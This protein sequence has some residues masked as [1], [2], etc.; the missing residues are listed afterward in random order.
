MPEIHVAAYMGDVQALQKH[1]KTDS[2]NLRAMNGIT[3]LMSA[4]FKRQQQTYQLLVQHGADPNLADDD[5]QDTLSYVM[6]KDMQSWLAFVIQMGSKPDPVRHRG[7]L[8]WVTRYQ[9]RSLVETILRISP[10]MIADVD[11]RR[12]GVLHTAIRHRRLVPDRD[13]MV[14]YLLQRGADPLALDRQGRSPLQQLLSYNNHKE[15][16][17]LESMLRNAQNA[18]ARVLQDPRRPSLFTV[19]RRER[20]IP[21]EDTHRVVE[22]VLGH[23]VCCMNPSLVQEISQ[24]L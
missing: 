16:V 2:P 17:P 12:N 8:V 10:G 5:G 15:N 11:D 23:V 9:P 3:P 4:L 18:V 13:A 20:K 22:E 1:L 24:M 21:L 7:L 19:M 14:A 6:N